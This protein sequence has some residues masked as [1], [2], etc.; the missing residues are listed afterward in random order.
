M[1]TVNNVTQHGGQ[2]SSRSW[3]QEKEKDVG[4]IE[5]EEKR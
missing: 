2:K 4:T 1:L 5:N 3:S